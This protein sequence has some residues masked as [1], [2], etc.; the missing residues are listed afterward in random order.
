MC[1]VPLVS[2]VMCCYNSSRYIRETINSVLCQTYSNFEFIIWNDGSNDDTES[3][4]KSFID[5]RIRYFYHENVG[6]G[7]ALMM[8]C[9]KVKGKYIARIDADDICLPYRIKKQVMYMESHKDCVLLSS[10]IEFIDENGKRLSRTYPCTDDFVLKSSLI[11][12]NMIVHPMVMMRAEAYFKAGGYLPVKFCEDK[13]FW[14]R[15]ARFGVFSN[16]TE[17][18]GKYRVVSNSLSHSDNPYGR[19]LYELRCKMMK[20]AEILLSDIELYNNLYDYSRKSPQKSS[21]FSVAEGKV[22]CGFESAFIRLF[23]YNSMLSLFI[24]MVKNVYYRY[25]GICDKDF[26]CSLQGTDYV[27]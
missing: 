6:L 4:V 18:L 2:F 23:F 21:Y 15:L 24:S 12:T 17:I 8:A 26:Y 7:R 5:E 1:T 10:A 25:S 16:I 22:K 14:S 9:K 27:K 3:I 13:L 20:D 11:A 19:T